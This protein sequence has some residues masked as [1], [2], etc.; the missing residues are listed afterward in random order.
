MPPSS[1][2][3][4]VH[5][6]LHAVASEPATR[7]AWPEAQR[8]RLTPTIRPAA[9]ELHAVASR[10]D[11]VPSAAAGEGLAHELTHV[12]Q[13]RGG[14]VAGPD[15]PTRAMAGEGDAPQAVA[16]EGD[17]PA[18]AAGEKDEPK[19]TVKQAAKELTNTGSAEYKVQWSV[20]DAK[21]NG[22]IIQHIRFSG[23]KKDCDG[24]DVATNT[25]GEEYWEAWQVR[26]GKVYVGSTANAHVADT[27]RTA[28]E[29]GST[30]GSLEISGKVAYKAGY[31]LKEPPWGHD[32]AAAGDLPTMK[33][34]PK[35]WDDSATKEHKMNVKW[36][37]CAKTPT[38]SV[39]TNP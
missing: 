30:V 20:S 32:V 21:A 2:R 35:D 25:T 13:R 22:W 24:K 8:E 9:H 3:G 19:I 11:A 12:A 6:Q 31:D 15:D 33:A 36:D 27:F 29:G 18:A 10:R 39:T 26:D 23:S 5:E 34:A 14:E 4:N 16:G 37:A 7:V 38:H 17:A 28:D 1:E